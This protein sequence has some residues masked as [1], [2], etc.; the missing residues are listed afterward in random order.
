MVSGAAGFSVSF[1]DA[2]SAPGY[3]LNAGFDRSINKNVNFGA[4]LYADRV[5]GGPTALTV[6]P[7]KD[8]QYSGTII[9]VI[10]HI[11]LN[12]NA[13]HDKLEFKVRLAFGIGQSWANGDFQNPQSGVSLY[14]TWGEP[15][16]IPVYTNGML[17]G[18]R[19]ESQTTFG[20]FAPSA[21]VGY[22]VKHNIKIFAR[23]G[24]LVAMSDDVD[25][26]NL[27]TSSNSNDDIFQVNHFGVGYL[28]YKKRFYRP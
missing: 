25:G 19:T 15:Y 27:P 28:L 10:P 21:S 9:S 22:F 2:L 4:S 1:T 26:L 14:K 3:G 18:A 5:F 23:V 8:Y 13:L 17:S 24:Y 11:D 16:F 6:N 7:S 20:V 12:L